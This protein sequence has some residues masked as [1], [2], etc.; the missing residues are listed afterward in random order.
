MPVTT[1]CVW[2]RKIV[3]YLYGVYVLW[4]CIH[5]YWNMLRLWVCMCA[6]VCVVSLNYFKKFNNCSNSKCVSNTSTL[7]S[8]T[9]NLITVKIGWVMVS[10][11][12][13]VVW[14]PDCNKREVFWHWWFWLIFVRLVTAHSF[15]RSNVLQN[16]VFLARFVGEIW[17]KFIFFFISNDAVLRYLIQYTK[18][19]LVT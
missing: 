3:T 2:L 17:L 7:S 9:R 1:F 5:T 10:S 14:N 16:S 6:C 18:K 19:V 8:V 15:C 12:L 13:C 4:Y 11:E